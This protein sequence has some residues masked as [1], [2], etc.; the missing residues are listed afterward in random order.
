[1]EVSVIIVNY[2]TSKLLKDCLVTLFDKTTELDFEVIVVDNASK[3]NSCEM[4]KTEFPQVNLIENQ[5]NLGFGVGNNIGIK[6]AKGKY[7]FLLNSDCELKN[8]AIKIIFDFMQNNPE[9]GAAGG[10]LFNTA[11]EH[12]AEFGRQYP[13]SEWIIV[14]SFLKF[15]FPQKYKYLRE[16]Q[17]NFDRTKPNE[18]GF[19]TGADLMIKKSVLDE[20]GLFNP[21][22]FLYFEET[23]LQW[24]IK[25]A[26][27]KIFL[28]PDS[29]IYHYEGMSP[30]PTKKLIM[31]RSEFM[32]FRL[33]QGFLSELVVRVL[34]FPKHLKLLIRYHFPK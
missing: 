2:N 22:F 16:Y 32:Y 31:L 27:Y 4:V 10:C 30:S 7:V 34:S 15:L 17:A 13:L 29:E 6:H 21:K 18:V 24:R 26:G 28:V 20:V 12:N 3:D 11:D 9:C 14:R 33:T 25:K 23:E 8:N 1:M 5:Q 19:I